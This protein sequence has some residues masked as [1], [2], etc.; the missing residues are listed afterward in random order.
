MKIKE[1]VIGKSKF[2]LLKIY[3]DSHL[4]SKKYNINQKTRS[5]LS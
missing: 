3:I 1:K 2:L 5:F 4:S